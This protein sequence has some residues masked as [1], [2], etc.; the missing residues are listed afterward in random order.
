MSFERSVLNRPLVITS[1]ELEGQTCG[2]A[3]ARAALVMA[4][5]R[6]VRAR[7]LL[8]SLML[9]LLA[10]TDALHLAL[11]SRGATRLLV[12]AQRPAALVME[13]MET[14]T[15]EGVVS[16]GHPHTEESRMKISRANKGKKPWNV[17]KKHS[18]ETKRKI[19]LKTR[20]AYL[21]RK[22]A[23][24]TRLRTEEPEKWAAMLA[25]KEAAVARAERAKEE[26]A[27]AALARKAKVLRS[28]PSLHRPCLRRPCLRRP[29]LHRR[30]LHRS[31]LRRPS[32]YRAAPHRSAPATAPATTLPPASFLAATAAAISAQRLRVCAAGRG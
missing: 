23:E 2:V 15:R 20:E 8:A 25:E 22:E 17:G 7:A 3:D 21:R 27:A 11:A 28:R 29:C 24:E 16:K 32:L 1:R 6:S 31:C 5:S 4:P 26:K 18:E 30:S 12:C 19:A 13:T 10:E 14:K 9:L